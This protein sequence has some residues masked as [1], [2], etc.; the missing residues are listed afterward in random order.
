VVQ[1]IDRAGQRSQVEDSVYWAG[2][3]KRLANIRF[4]KFET[5]LTAQVFD[6]LYMTGN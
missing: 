2:N 4:L 1:I 5:G 6:I 3:R